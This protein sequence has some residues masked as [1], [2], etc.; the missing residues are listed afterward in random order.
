MK[1]Q[2]LLFVLLTV[3]L[4]ASLLFSSCGDD[5]QE[6]PSEDVTESGTSGVSDGTEF[7]S[8]SS[9]GSTSTES[10]GGHVGSGDDM[11]DD[12]N[13][14]EHTCVGAWTVTR[15]ATC[16]E[17]GEEQLKCECGKVLETRVIAAGHVIVKQDALAAT[18]TGEGR[19]AYEFCQRC[20]Y[21]TYKTVKALGH[22]K[23]THAAKAPT[24]TEKGHEAYDACTRCDYS[25]FV[26]V[27][28]VDHVYENGLCKWCQKE[29]GGQPFAYSSNGDGT[30][31]LTGMGECKD[32]SLEIPLKAE[33]GEYV[34]AI[35][36]NAFA[37]Q[38]IVS[39]SFETGSRVT[40]IGVA[41]FDGCARLSRLT[42]PDGLKTIFERAFKGCKSLNSL[43]IPSSVESIGSSAFRGC[44]KL[45]EVYNLSSHLTVTAGE[46]TVNGLLGLYALDVYTDQNTPSCIR[47]EKD[48]FVF[49]EKGDER[50]LL[51]RTGSLM[52]LSLP[53]DLDGK[54]Y[55]VYRYAFFG[56]ALL[57][58]L[59]IPEKVTSIGQYAFAGCESLLDV[60]FD[61]ESTLARIEANAFSE[62]SSLWQFTLPESLAEIKGGAFSKCYAL[63]EIFD[64]S[65]AIKVEA[66]NEKDH[67]GIGAYAIGVYTSRDAVS[68]VFEDGEGFR[69]YAETH[70][71]YLV[72]YTGEKTVLTLPVSC[73]GEEYRIYRYAFFG[74]TRVT[75]VALSGKVSGIGEYAFSGCTALADVTFSESVVSIDANAFFGCDALTSA[76]FAKTS[77][78]LIAT[79][80][81]AISG[82]GVKATELSDT[83][84]AAKYLRSTYAARYWRYMPPDPNWS[85]WY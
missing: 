66:K 43:T 58:H 60:N 28:T 25:T 48:G 56:D 63:V 9:T 61:G 29:Y 20:D 82:T 36:E 62:C 46:D 59:T 74:N 1:K 3:A 21:N 49:Y 67:G 26:E 32:T 10:G 34:V 72:G 77:G 54:S 19:E 75:S 51:G 4:L 50:Y 24:C 41:A 57:T 79:T 18:C 81:S 52:R 83:A 37:R 69:F 68:R 55:S 39:V 80:A 8:G 2:G 13:D 71:K 5:A 65:A 85:G 27:S 53:A 73:L 17:A 6:T 23:K 45:I 35:G 44:F 16:L 84:T 64:F 14:P 12:G 38:N 11:F 76:A 7:E 42:L 70:S 47:T 31:T 40:S 30:C 22:D 78:W 33:N 15:E